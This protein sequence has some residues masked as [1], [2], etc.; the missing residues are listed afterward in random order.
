M[1]IVYAITKGNWGGAQRYVFDLAIAAKAAGHDVAVAHGGTGS[2]VEKLTLAGVRTIAI[3][4]LVRDVGGNDWGAYQALK[5]TI[6]EEKPD[7]LHLNSSKAGAMGALAGRIVGVQKIIYTSHGWAFREK[8]SLPARVVIW[9]ISWLTALLSHT[10]IA[11]SDSELALAKQM[12]F[13][14]K[15]AVRI[16]NGI[17]LNMSFGSGE[18][19]R[20]AFPAGVKITG[21]VGELTK[22]KNQIALVEEAKNTPGMYVAI[23]GEGELRQMLETRLVEYGLKD[24]VK[25]F[26]FQ[27]AADVLKGFDV[28]ALPSF[29]EGLAYV[30][31]EA[32]TAGLPIVASR[33]GGIPEA[34]DKPLSEF[35]KEK[36]VEQTFA[37]YR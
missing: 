14:S 35:S 30:I 27:P 8:R 24:R 25:L 13:C 36:M 11:V 32:R 5:K 16:Y 33:I 1:K 4:G 19:I 15:K 22:N 28:F 12:P 2:M 31:L 10:V 34:M 9:L 23:V 29:K 37:L 7:V 18:I 20:S 26:G 6:R 21:T 17:D 3:P